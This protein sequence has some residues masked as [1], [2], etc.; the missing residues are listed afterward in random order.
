MLLVYLDVL[1]YFGPEQKQ[2]A[3][4][5]FELPMATKKDRKKEN[6][7]KLSSTSLIIC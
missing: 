3:A 6:R 5:G 7:Y 4:V 1:K 2:K